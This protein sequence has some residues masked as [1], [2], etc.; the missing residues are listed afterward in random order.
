[1]R[2]KSV[3]VFYPAYN[4]AGTIATMIIRAAQTLLTTEPDSS[5]LAIS[6]EIGF[7]SQSNFY[8]AFKEITGLAP[9]DYRKSLAK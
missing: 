3:S 4:D 6:M 1:M 5:I 9:G 2:L 8:A 7:K